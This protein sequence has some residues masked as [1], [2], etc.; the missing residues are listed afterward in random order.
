[1]VRYE[2]MR[3]NPGAVLGRILDFTGTPATMGQ[4][5]DAVEFAAYDNHKKKEQA[6][7]FSPLRGGWRL[8]PGNRDNPDSFKVRRAKVGGY[9]DYFTDQELARI[10]AMVDSDLLPVIG[11]TSGES[12]QAPA[13]VA[14]SG[15]ARQAASGGVASRIRRASWR[16]WLRRI[17]PSIRASSTMPDSRHSFRRPKKNR[18]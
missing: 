8:V 5:A 15:E 3:E 9:R 16:I 12:G 10:D 17:S 2:D 4:I 18:S 14:G 11:Y 1:M 6:T 7:R 13:A